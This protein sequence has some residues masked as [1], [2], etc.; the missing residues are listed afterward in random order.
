MCNVNLEVY[1][2]QVNRE[3]GTQYSIPVMYFT[4]L[5]E[6][7]LSIAAGRLRIPKRASANAPIPRPL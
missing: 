3:F 2:E 5:M 1:Q 4:Q 7:A 6:T